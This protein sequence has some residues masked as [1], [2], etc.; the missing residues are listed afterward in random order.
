MSALAASEH[1]R[2]N[3][4][5]LLHRAALV[6]KCRHRR[7]GF[8]LPVRAGYG[9]SARL[10]ISPSIHWTSLS[11][12]EPRR[13]RDPFSV[14]FTLG[15]IGNVTVS[16]LP[17]P[18]EFERAVIRVDGGV[19]TA[20]SFRLPSGLETGPNTLRFGPSSQS[21]GILVLTNGSYAAFASATISNTLFPEG[22]RVRGN[23]SGSYDA[24]TGRATVQ[25]QSAD[26]F[27]EPDRLR[28]TRTLGDFWLNWLS[29]GILETATN[30]LGP[31]VSQT[32]AVSPHAL[33]TTRQPQ[34][35]FRVRQAA[36]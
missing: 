12:N 33:D 23:Y 34:K 26:S 31:W 22:I 21:S 3:R 5:N 27:R 4:W 7:L 17:I 20:P 10:E 9:R 14:W 15:H 18:N 8:A 30:V 35:F 24:V 6:E 19:F 25:S 11:M 1:R 2:H 13:K 36:S 32:N 28:T 29:G 16:L